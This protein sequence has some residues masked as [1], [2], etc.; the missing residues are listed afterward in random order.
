MKELKKVYCKKCG[1]LIDCQTKECTGCGKQYMTLKLFFKE[2]LAAIIWIIL[3]EIFVFVIISILLPNILL[4]LQNTPVLNAILNFINA[5]VGGISFVLTI[6]AYS[7]AG[8]FPGVI[9]NKLFKS[10]RQPVS[11]IICMVYLFACVLIAIIDIIL[12]KSNYI[13]IF[14]YIVLSIA[15]FLGLEE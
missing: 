8:F 1:S 4:F 5:F 10:Q 7:A 14:Y 3:Y 11:V 15:A 6:T 2:L 13:H 12:I 9:V